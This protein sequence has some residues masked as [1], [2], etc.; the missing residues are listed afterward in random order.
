MTLTGKNHALTAL[1][2]AALFALVS[3]GDGGSADE[4]DADADVPA[5]SA[6]DP[7][8]G[9]GGLDGEAD[10]EDD[11]DE[12][13]DAA[14]DAD[15]EENGGPVFEPDPAR[16]YDDIAYLASVELAGREAATA[17][18]E[19]ALQYVEELFTGLGL[20]PA[21]DDGTYRH[22]FEFPMWALGAP[23]S[24]S[25]N[26]EDLLPIDEFDVYRY[27]GSAA[28]DGRIVFVGYGVVVPPFDPDEYPSCPLDPGGYDDFAGM[29]VDGA[30]LLKY[31]GFP[32]GD[33]FGAENCPTESGLEAAVSHGA[34]A[35]LS[36][37]DDWRPPEILHGVNA[38][39]DGEQ[40][41]LP[42][43][44]LDRDVAEALFPDMADRHDDIND[45]LRPSSIETG[46]EASLSVE[47]TV[48]TAETS[49]IV[50][51]LPGADPELGDE[52]VV[53]GGHVDH[54]WQ[55]PGSGIIFPGADDNASGT[56]I[57]ME[58]ARG[59]AWTIPSP[60]RT[61]V[62]AAWNAEESGLHGSCAY[63]D[64]PSHPIESMIAMINLDSIGGGSGTGFWVLGGGLAV[65]RWLVEVMV[66]AQIE[67]RYEGVVRS[68]TGSQSSDHFCFAGQ[69]VPVMSL[70]TLG[71]HTH[72]H[73]QFDTIDV[74]NLDELD[75]GSHL[76][77]WTLE[78]LANGT[79]GRYLDI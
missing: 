18:N 69:G 19:L 36:V 43:L 75:V 23:P 48:T 13:E 27:S 47:A 68:A 44:L 64:R 20:E 6:G 61:I 46:L 30:V 24:L 37:S 67:H 62:F 4:G 77:W 16:I 3:C 10:V 71:D 42:V 70:T 12:E 8:A 65:N 40:A 38:T 41:P 72:V 50:G 45:T 79:E 53:V 55:D 49:N 56:A 76:L 33:Y 29:D 26:G 22:T 78:A 52:V 1:F 39:R 32:T 25:V 58:L 73:T 9:E 31:A 51:A 57:M 21:G 34:L 60:A 7:D 63:V 54:E 5:E 35:I 15:E 17:G 59:A 2:P 74:I 11:P 66:G 28:A 14:D